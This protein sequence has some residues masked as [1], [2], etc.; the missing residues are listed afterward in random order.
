M[1]FMTASD[2]HG[3]EKGRRGGDGGVGGEG[4][5][6]GRQVIESDQRTESQKGPHKLS[7]PETLKER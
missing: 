5:L 4:A 7:F 1:W 2:G 6:R 3:E